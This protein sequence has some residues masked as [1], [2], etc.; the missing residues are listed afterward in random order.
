MLHHTPAVAAAACCR[1]NGVIDENTLVWGQVSFSVDYGLSSISGGS[2]AYSFHILG[3]EAAVLL[4]SWPGCDMQGL[5][6]F[7]PICNVRTLVPQIR[8]VEG[9]ATARHSG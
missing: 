7:L 1:V 4:S 8:T 3:S 5:F 6:D 9:E 2:W